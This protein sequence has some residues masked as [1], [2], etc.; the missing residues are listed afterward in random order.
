MNQRDDVQQR[1]NRIN[2]ELVWAATLTNMNELRCYAASNH[3]F[4]VLWYPADSGYGLLL[5]AGESY[6]APE[7]WAALDARIEK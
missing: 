3:V 7:A 4:Y 2:A 1:L 6:G 5:T